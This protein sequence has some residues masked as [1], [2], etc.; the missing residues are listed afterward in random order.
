M[1]DYLRRTTLF[2]KGR[3]CRAQDAAG[4]GTHSYGID[5]GNQITPC[6]DALTD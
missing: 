4:A 3:R 1:F 6:R 5:G 2:E